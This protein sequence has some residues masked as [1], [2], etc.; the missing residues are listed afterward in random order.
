MSGHL[1]RGL[2]LTF[3]SFSITLSA[4]HADTLKITSTPPGA[5]VEING[6]VAGT[7][8]Y[9]TNFPSGYFHKPHSV[10]SARLGHDMVLRISKRGFE[11]QKISIT[12]GPFVWIGLNGRRHGNYWL[13]KCASVDAVLEPLST[14]A[15]DAFEEEEGAG[16]IHPHN[17]PEEH[18]QTTTAAARV[19]E[20]SD[21]TITSEPSGADIYVDGQFVGQT[22]STISLAS[23]A[24]HFAVKAPGKKQWVRDVDVLPGS[25]ITLHPVLEPLP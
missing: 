3:A 13:L 1:I 11:A 12:D 5:T 2:I 8:P 9:E 17:P 23:G 18:A 21:A 20:G 25:K 15:A 24:H 10:F 4:S 19:A 22:P 16:P 6:I 14:G 7:T